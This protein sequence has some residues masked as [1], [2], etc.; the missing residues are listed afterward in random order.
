M[1]FFVRCPTSLCNQ[2]TKSDIYIMA[3]RDKLKQVIINVFMNGIEAMEYKRAALENCPELTL[4]VRITEASGKVYIVIRD[5]GI[6]MTESE[7]AACRDPFF[8]TKKAGTG[9]GLALCEQYIRENNG[10]MQIDSVKNQYTRISLI[11]ERS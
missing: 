4:I 10:A 9:L 5:E 1:D 3:D 7:L 2:P 11:F 8:S 6:G